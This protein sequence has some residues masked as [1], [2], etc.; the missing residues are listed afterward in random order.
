MTYCFDQA[1]QQVD[2]TM[3]F[4]DMLFVRMSK[5]LD[6]LLEQYEVLRV[7]FVVQSTQLEAAQEAISNLQGN[8]T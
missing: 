2:V 8:E 7:D 6:V 4:T 5:G 3:G 1:E